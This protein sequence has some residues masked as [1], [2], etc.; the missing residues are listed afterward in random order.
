MTNEKSGVGTD[1]STVSEH[2]SGIATTSEAEIS[3]IMR[4]G[5]SKGV[6]YEFGYEVLFG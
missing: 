6:R 1:L 3:F 4:L 2:P 5:L